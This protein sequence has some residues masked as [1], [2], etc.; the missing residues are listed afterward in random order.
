LMAEERALLQ[1]RGVPPFPLDD[2]LQVA[3]DDIW[4]RGKRDVG[5]RR[6]DAALARVPLASLDVQRRPYFELIAL[7]AFA[8]RPQEARALLARY[9][10][11]VTDSSMRRA[12]VPP[13]LILLGAIALAETGGRDAITEFRLADCYPDGPASECTICLDAPLGMAYEMAGMPDSAIAVYEH[14]LRTPFWGRHSRDLDGTW[15]AFTLRRLGALYEER[16]AGKATEHYTRFVALWKDAD[17]DL[18]PRV[19]EVRRRLEALRL[20][21]R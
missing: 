17:A 18:Q 10:A 5:I 6:L 1:A 15:L 14:Y 12:R 19:A 9:D 8:Q 4:L 2:S 20:R 3:A 11:E 7:N 16:D 13:R 21:E